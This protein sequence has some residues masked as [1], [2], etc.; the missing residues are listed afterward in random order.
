MFL[1][2][3]NQNNPSNDRLE[4][5]NVIPGSQWADTRNNPFNKT[6]IEITNVR[7]KFAQYKFVILNNEPWDTGNLF[8]VALDRFHSSYIHPESEQAKANNMGL[9]LED[10]RTFVQEQEHEEQEW[11]KYLR[12]KR[13]HDKF[14]DREEAPV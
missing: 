2:M 6:I 9:S 11:Q 7:G 12:E 1:V 5:V 14:Y 13:G 3:M 10:Y 8:S 4:P